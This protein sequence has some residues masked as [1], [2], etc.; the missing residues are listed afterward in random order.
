MIYGL[1]IHRG[2]G[3]HAFIMRQWTK[4]QSLQEEQLLT[5]HI[6]KIIEE[7][8]SDG[9]LLAEKIA[10]YVREH[11]L[12]M[13]MPIDL[14]G[15]AR[16]VN[17][18]QD[19]RMEMIQ[20]SVRVLAQKLEAAE[21]KNWELEYAHWCAHVYG[22]GASYQLERTGEIIRIASEE[23]ECGH[24]AEATSKYEEWKSKHLN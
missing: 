11:S 13:E 17:L 23:L 24:L 18:S 1:I 2:L 15:I 21:R 12:K 16:S 20:T 10:A 6:V 7:E 19:K 22:V 3:K 14:T 8:T 4:F 9:F 5:P